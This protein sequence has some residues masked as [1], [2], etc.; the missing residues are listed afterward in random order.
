[1]ADEK[2]QKEESH[3]MKT[4]HKTRISLDEKQAARGV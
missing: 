4:T 1:M 2:Q 3:R